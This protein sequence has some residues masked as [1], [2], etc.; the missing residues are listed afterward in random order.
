MTCSFTWRL[1]SFHNAIK[2]LK[3]FHS[4]DKAES[5][6]HVVISCFAYF[7]RLCMKEQDVSS[8]NTW[9]NKKLPS[10]KRIKFV[11]YLTGLF[12]D[13]MQPKLKQGISS[14]MLIYWASA[15]KFFR[16][17]LFLGLLRRGVASKKKLPQIF[18]KII[19]VCT[20]T[21]W[22]KSL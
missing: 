4:I 12:L 21:I 16:K 18:F 5:F 6:F 1:V 19:R 8:F 2:Y 11:V 3:S 7:S 17:L 15:M 13:T 14:A 9:E 10:R 20:I 22:M